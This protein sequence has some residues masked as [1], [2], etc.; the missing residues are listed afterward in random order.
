MD[1]YLMCDDEVEM[2]ELKEF[3]YYFMEYFDQNLTN[4]QN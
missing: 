3:V 2:E 4:K 1:Q